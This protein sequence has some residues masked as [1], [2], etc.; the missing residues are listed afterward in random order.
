MYRVGIWL[1]ALAFVFNG[2]A[3]HALVDLPDLIAQDHHGALAVISHDAHFSDST[4]AATPDHDQI[5]EHKH[6]SRRCCDVCNLASV[7]PNVVVVPV[8]FSYA[9][10]V[11]A[12]AQ[13]F[14]VG[15][16]IAIDPDIPKTI[17]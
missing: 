16:L 10:V 9:A 7:I 17:V 2:A 4:V 8:P 15:H 14:L 12:A 11:F 5:P 3:S 13:H 1:M 6:N